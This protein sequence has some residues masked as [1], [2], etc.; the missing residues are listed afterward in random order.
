MNP[1]VGFTSEGA[2]LLAWTNLVALDDDPVV[3]TT[4]KPGASEFD[5]HVVAVTGAMGGAPSFSSGETPFLAFHRD[6][7]NEFDILI[8]NALNSDPNAPVLT[9]GQPGRIDHTPVVVATDDGG[10]VAWYRNVSGFRNDLFVQRFWYDETGFTAGVE[11]QIITAM[12]V[13]P[14]PPALTSVGDNVFFIA[15]SEGQSP[16]L[17][18]KGQFIEL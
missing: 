5:P 14:Y 12:P 8:K 13:A 3:H 15:W 18:L 6:L 17:F 7:G 4:L 9:L 1:A 16:E 11:T 10:V 2:V